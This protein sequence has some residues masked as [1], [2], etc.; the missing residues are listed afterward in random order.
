MTGGAVAPGAGCGCDSGC[1]DA[2]CDGGGS[3]GHRF[4]NRM[5]G[6]FSRGGRHGGDGCDCG[7]APAPAVTTA[8]CGCGTTDCCDSGGHGFRNR[9][10]GLFSRGGRHGGGDCGCAT[11]CG[12]CGA[13]YGAP[14]GA[15]A[16]GRVGEQIPPPKDGNIKKMP[17]DGDEPPAKTGIGGGQLQ[18]NVAPAAPIPAVAPALEAAPAVGPG[19]A[20][21]TE[22]RPF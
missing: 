2:C 5:R 21:N 7:C 13:P 4:K 20:A 1:G 9:L 8:T 15:P 10:R 14:Y 22:E 6:L 11:D 16:A 19:P 17:K 18:I 3:W 12:G